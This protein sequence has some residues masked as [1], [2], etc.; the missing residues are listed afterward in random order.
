MF[1]FNTTTIINSN[2]DFTNPSFDLFKGDNTSGKEAFSVARGLTFKKPFVKA[3]YKRN[4]N[5]EEKAKVEIDFSGITTAGVYRVAMYIQLEGS[6][7]E[8]YANDYVFKG[9][10]FYI[11]FVKKTSTKVAAKIKKTADKYMNLVYDYPLLKVTADETSTNDKITIEAI[12]GYQRFTMVELQQYGNTSDIING[13]CTPIGEFSTIAALKIDADHT[14]IAGTGSSDKIKWVESSSVPLKGKCGFG[15]YRQIIKDLRLPTA[16]NRRW[17]GII[18]DE[19][20]IPGKKYTQFTI[21]Y[22]KKVGIQGM[23]HVGDV[24]QAMTSHIFFVNEDV[25][26]DW[27]TELAKLGV[28]VTTVTDGTYTK[29]PDELELEATTGTQ[30]QTTTNATNIGTLAAAVGKLATETSTTGDEITAAAALIPSNG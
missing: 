21:W 2:K 23:D 20:P 10:P 19:A 3:I 12:D 14:Y 5:D 30:T 15:T 28:T 17:G 1:K 29:T 7:N 24:V 16:D 6:A 26:S 8:Y 11:E 27:N 9:K 18:A 13:C 4:P 25:L 22:C